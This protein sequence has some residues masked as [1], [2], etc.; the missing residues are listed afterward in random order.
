MRRNVTIYDVSA[1]AGVSACSVSWVLHNH[2]RSR[3]LSP[4]T[5]QR[6]LDTA[7][8]LGYVVNRLASATSTGK[9]DTIAVI[10][11]FYDMLN[12]SMNQI[13]SGIMMETAERKYSVKVFSESD[14]AGAFQAIAENRIGK[15]ISMSVDPLPREKC[16][17]LAEKY[18]L[19]LVYAYER[20]HRNFPAV[21]VDN[22]EMTSR[23]VHYLAERGHSRIGLLCGPHTH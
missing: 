6:I 7:E 11:N 9:V 8:K 20:G 10:L 18:T 17:E 4:T 16:A 12:L 2:P 22:T 1:A 19:D 23:A 15:V 14:L 13:M 21:N 3:K 5:R